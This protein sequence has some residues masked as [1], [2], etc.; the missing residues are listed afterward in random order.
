MKIAVLTQDDKI[1]D[2]IKQ[3][4]GSIFDVSFY[5][6]FSYFFKEYH[7]FDLVLLD[8]AFVTNE[9]LEIVSRN[10][11]E[12]GV[13]SKGKIDFDNEKIAI[14][15]DQEE[16]DKIEEKIRYFETKIR[17][18][19][20]VDVEQRNLNR[21]QRLTAKTDFWFLRKQKNQEFFE[22]I[23]N[24]YFY[25]NIKEGVF[26][27]EIRDVLRDKQIAE[28]SNLLQ[29]HNFKAAIYFGLS[30]ITSNHLATLI[31][32]W[33]IVKANNGKIVYWNKLNERKIISFMKL[34][35]L[36]NIIKVYND[37]ESVKKEIKGD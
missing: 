28:L 26:I 35:N 11:L 34:C 6:D 21:I 5:Q 20:L 13:L 30:F 3:K 17:I 32:I 31:S 18:K 10:N 25:V 19:N 23:I 14:I 36:E 8:K 37:F 16:I 7:N 33:K 29:Q 4:I 12:I 24:N 22:K 1:L 9:I 2:R 27:I 15:L